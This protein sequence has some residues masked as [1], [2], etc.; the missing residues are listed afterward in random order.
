MNKLEGD[1]NMEQMQE[2]KKQ[3]T[4]EAKAASKERKEEILEELM[5]ISLKQALIR[6][7]EKFNAN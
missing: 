3:L 6:L 7:E 5:N 1:M 2:L 4:N